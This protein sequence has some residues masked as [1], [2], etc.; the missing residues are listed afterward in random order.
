MTMRGGLMKDTHKN[1]IDLLYNKY[2]KMLIII[3]FVIY[4]LFLCYIFFFRNS[5]FASRQLVSY[6]FIPFKS[7]AEYIIRYHRMNFNIWF[8]N[9]FG[10][11]L[12]FVPFG[13]FAPYL[14]RKLNNK[15]TVFTTILLASISVELLQILLKT[16][17]FDVDDIFLNILGGLLGYSLLF[18]VM[19]R[20]QQQT[21]GQDY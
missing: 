16:G 12:V 20:V 21:K 17:T 7:I 15:L 11:I 10:N 6:N 19:S 5:N 14:F 9:L 3:L 8:L 4:I 13:F 18:L 2:I 1:K